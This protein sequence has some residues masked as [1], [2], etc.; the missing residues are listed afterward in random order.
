MLTRLIR[1]GA[2][3]TALL[4]AGTALAQ[5]VPAPNDN[6]QIT[7]KGRKDVKREIRAFVGALAE[8][9]AIKQ[10]SRFEDAVCP[11]TIGLGPD[12]GIAINDRLRQ[13][14]DAAGMKSADAADCYPNVL[15]AITSDRNAFIKALVRAHPDYFG[16]FT[17][18]Q[19]RQVLAQP[20][21]AAAWHRW[22]PLIT[23]RGT[24]V[25]EDPGSGAGNNSMAINMTTEPDTRS[26]NG[27]RPQFQGA[28]VVIEAKAV[29]G[30]TTTQVADYAAM[31]AFAATHPERLEASTSATIL[32]VIDAP[33]GAEVPASLTRWD[34]GYLRGL[35][36]SNPY[37]LAGAQR[38][39]IGREIAAQM[40]VASK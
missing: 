40:G 36:T 3:A 30:L 35:Y 39:A 34:L 1:T 26:S 38:G 10:L 29:E 37:L 8:N 27:V 33:M 22:G 24:P 5:E 16:E 4:L 7:V 14:A 25:F 18:M 19:V 17:P 31:R 2:C 15:V 6:S 23:K 20:G 32:K 21:P 9:P 13:V 12:Q 11:V 28:V